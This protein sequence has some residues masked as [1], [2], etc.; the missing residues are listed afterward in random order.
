MALPVTAAEMRNKQQPQGAVDPNVKIPRAVIEAGKRSEEI[1]RAITGQAEPSVVA[2]PDDVGAAPAEVT[3]PG[4]SSEPAPQSQA[5]P[6]AEAPVPPAQVPPPAVEGEASWEHKFKSLQGRLESDSR[7]QREM[8][9]Q[10]SERVEAL[11]RENQVLRTAQPT[12]QE[13]NGHT[14][15]SEQE[16]ADYGPEFVDVMRRVVADATG[17]LQDEIQ[18]LRGQLGHVQQETGNAF[19]SRMNST[20]NAM[21]PGW[22]EMNKDPRFIQWTQLPDIFSGAIRR[23]LMQGAWNSGDPHRVAAF[24]QAYLAEEA[25]TNP[26]R[27]AEQRTLPPSRMTVTPSPA[28][29]P[30]PATPGAPFDLSLL[31]APGRAHSA[32]GSPAE[33]PVYTSA[34]ITKFYTDVA[35]GRWRHREAERAA[36]DADIMMAQREGRIF[37]DPRNQPP[38]DPFAR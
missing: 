18:N 25:A 9:T 27:A 8:M 23:E 28:N 16:I 21:V 34:D 3:P 12:T 17:P 11:T 22:S 13:P 35:A 29:S 24:F 31:A 26:Q 4:N 38:K 14:S 6:P 32:G 19:L 30:S 33:K 2:S 7:R 10:L 5:P 37:V 1:Q 20:L 15:L 36:I